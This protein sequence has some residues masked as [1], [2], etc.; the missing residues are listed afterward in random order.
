MTISVGVTLGAALALV[1]ALW[2]LVAARLSSAPVGASWG[3]RRVWRAVSMARGAARSR[4]V[5]SSPRAAGGRVAARRV[6]GGLAATWAPAAPG[7]SAGWRPVFQKTRTVQT[8]REPSP[9]NRKVWTD[10][11]GRVGTEE[12]RGRTETPISTARI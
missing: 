3:P 1:V 12:V 2:A 7:A 11:R 4:A 8:G 6:A 10:S 5:L 9:E